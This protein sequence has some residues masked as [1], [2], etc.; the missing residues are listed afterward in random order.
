MNRKAKHWLT[1]TLIA[2]LATL[3]GTQATAND[4]NQVPLTGPTPY[5]LPD[6]T[7][8]VLNPSCSNGPVLNGDTIEAA[9]PQFSFFYQLGDPQKLL[10]ALDGGGGCWD[11]L[12][13]LGSP[14]LDNSVYDQTVNET[15]AYAETVGG[16]VDADNPDNPYRDYTKVF[17]P[18][19]T[20]DV[21][22]GSRD[23]EY[24]LRR[25]AQPDL[26]WVIR[27]R[28]TDNLLAVLQWLRTQGLNEGV[29]L[30]SLSHLTVTGA[31][32]G[33]Y[34]ATLTFPYVASL[35]PTARM[36]L[37]A[38]AGV[39]VINESFYRT[40][41]YDPA[42]PGA[43][44]WGVVDSVPS[45]MGLNEAFL[46]QYANKPLALLPAW[47]AELWRYRPWSRMAVLTSN[48]DTVQIGFYGLMELLGGRLDNLLQIPVEWYLK[49][50]AITNATEALPNYRT[51]IE[52][53]DYHTVIAEDR[54]Y[55][56]GASGVSVREWNDAMLTA[57]RAGWQTI[58]VGSPF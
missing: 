18:Y 29:D 54:Y 32:A 23:T 57:P 48:R 8:R 33:A 9:D 12:T 3:T 40:A 7:T 42:N 21:H 45:F 44:S 19:C 27:H 24:T 16:L 52:D 47:Y 58:D 22:W 28:G 14:L 49:M 26:K 20:G 41:L 38:D 55:Q 6:G 53:G 39:G 51:F 43:A 10:I 17:I 5:L 50:Q 15:P 46:A 4:W 25:L 1:G 2:G 11:A 13:C 36:T 35:A 31:S 37:I 56:P 30:G 34:G